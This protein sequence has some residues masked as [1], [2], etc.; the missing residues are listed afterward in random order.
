MSI[1]LRWIKWDL[2]N[3]NPPTGAISIGSNAQLFFQVLQY[4]KRL[5]II[6]WSEWEN[7]P[8]STTETKTGSN[9]VIDIIDE[10]LTFYLVE[11]TICFNNE[12]K[13]K[14]Y[15]YK[16]Q[17]IKNALD[18]LKKSRNKGNQITFSLS[19]WINENESKEEKL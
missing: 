5:N 15:L 8:F 2:K 9:E 7:I 16:F 18:I 17:P 19:A 6:Q 12:A 14:K 3:G 10:L 4:R 13:A 1:E 11:K